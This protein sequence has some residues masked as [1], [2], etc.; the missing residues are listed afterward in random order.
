MTDKGIKKLNDFEK[1]VHSFYSKLKQVQKQKTFQLV[2]YEVRDYILFA[3]DLD[4]KFHGSLMYA[5]LR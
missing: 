5:R 4:T 2:P 3:E 1:L